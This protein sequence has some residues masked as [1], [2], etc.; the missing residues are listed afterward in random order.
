V[1]PWN[2]HSDE[3]GLEQQFRGSESLGLDGDHVSVGE[4]EG[5]VVGS[6]LLVF[7][8]LSLVVEGDVAQLLLDV[9]NDFSLGG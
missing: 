8:L 4:L 7:G 2:F 3:G 9:S 1:N 5:L 6:G